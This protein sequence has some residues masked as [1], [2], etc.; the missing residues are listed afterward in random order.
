MTDTEALRLCACGCGEPIVP[1]PHHRYN[2]PRYIQGHHQRVRGEAFRE[3]VRAGHLKRRMKPPPDWAVPSGLCECG[4]GQRTKIARAHRKDVDQYAGY[5]ERYVRGH[6]SRGLKGALH[7]SWKGGRRVAG[8][9]Y[10]SVLRPDHPAAT[11]T[12]YV[13]EHRLVYE[14]TRGVRLPARAVVH[15]ING[16]PTDNRPENLIAVTR[17]EHAK[18][19]R[20]ANEL[21]SLF[22]DD[23]LLEAAK[24]HVREHGTLPDLEA[25]T[26]QVYGH[27]S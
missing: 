19:H 12:G 5:P 7:P 21:I 14:E 8:G 3:A 23:K 16:L 10:V 2:P 6:N 11:S 22:L 26:A 27:Q 25:L 9:R 1:K 17:G 15:H 24:A 20:L 4:C 18:T 13:L